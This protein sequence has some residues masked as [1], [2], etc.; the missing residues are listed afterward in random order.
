MYKCHIISSTL[1]LVFPPPENKRTLR[2]DNKS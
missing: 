1:E 2:K